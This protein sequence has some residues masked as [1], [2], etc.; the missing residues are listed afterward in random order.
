MEHWRVIRTPRTRPPRPIE[1]RGSLLAMRALAR[2]DAYLDGYE[3]PS[4]APKTGC[5]Y[6]ANPGCIA[7]SRVTALVGQRDHR[8][9]EGRRR[10]TTNIS[11][12]EQRR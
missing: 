7:L 3:R 1:L 11:R 8:A 5:H 4:P 6:C 2:A 9:Y 12:C 10:L